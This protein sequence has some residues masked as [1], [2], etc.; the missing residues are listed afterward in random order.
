MILTKIQNKEEFFNTFEEKNK[1]GASQLFDFVKNYVFSQYDDRYNKT[2]FFYIYNTNYKEKEIYS[3]VG[4]SKENGISFTAIYYK[5]HNSIFLENDIIGLNDKTAKNNTIVESI[6]DIV[7]SPKYY[8][9]SIANFTYMTFKKYS[10]ES[11][12]KLY[13]DK[14][15]YG[16]R[17][18][19]LPL[20]YTDKLELL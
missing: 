4:K 20:N 17:I 1:E 13:K 14:N 19:R 2:S 6:L 16:I 10:F 11:F 15:Y 7:S 5:L 9:N 12:N 18:Y 3:R 8:Q